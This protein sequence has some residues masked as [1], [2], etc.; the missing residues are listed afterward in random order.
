MLFGN[1]IIENPFI[2]S[3]LQIFDI[4]VAYHYAV[5]IDSCMHACLPTVLDQPKHHHMYNLDYSGENARWA[6][7]EYL[8]IFKK[9]KLR[10]LFDRG[11]TA[12]FKTFFNS[13]F[14]KKPTNW[15]SFISPLAHKHLMDHE[16]QTDRRLVAK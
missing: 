14:S 3:I 9:D 8:T 1:S 11:F 2:S 10:S 6:K 16:S 4:T 15:I 13:S 5:G 7:I 12:N